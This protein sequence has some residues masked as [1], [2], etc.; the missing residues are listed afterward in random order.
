[1]KTIDLVEGVMSAHSPAYNIPVIVS[2]S[3]ANGLKIWY[4]YEGNCGS[5]YLES[6]CYRILKEEA[7]ERGFSIAN[8]SKQISPTML[9]QVLFERYK[10]D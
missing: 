2:L 8:T 6:I 5:C 3:K 10:A 4:L 1:V 7:K 9:A